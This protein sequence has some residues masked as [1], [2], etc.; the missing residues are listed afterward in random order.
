M[1]T[2]KLLIIAIVIIA[3]IVVIMVACVCLLRDFVKYFDEPKTKT[4]QENYGK[5]WQEKL[6]LE[7]EVKG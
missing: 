2:L 5:N 1:D 4:M 7:E 6:L 3:I